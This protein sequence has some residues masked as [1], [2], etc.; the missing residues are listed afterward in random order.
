[1]REDV[2][3]YSRSVTTGIKNIDWAAFGTHDLCRYHGGVKR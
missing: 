1:M 2:D 3:L